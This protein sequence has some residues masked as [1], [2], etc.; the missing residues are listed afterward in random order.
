[1]RKPHQHRLVLDEWFDLFQHH[2]SRSISVEIAWGLRRPLR[3][4]RTQHRAEAIFEHFIFVARAALAGAA[5]GAARLL[6]LLLH[7]AEATCS[8][9]FR[10]QHLLNA[11]LARLV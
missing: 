5:A 9:R 8:A 3:T 1:M 6:H 2:A 7:F 4:Y 11:T 10:T